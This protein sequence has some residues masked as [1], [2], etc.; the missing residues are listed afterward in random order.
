MKTSLQKAGMRM[1]GE[2]YIATVLD[3]IRTAWDAQQDAL[4]GAADRIAQT[5]AAKHSVF[6][7]GCSHAGMLAE[8]VFYR[9]GGLAVLNPI[10]F[11]GVAL[12]T[13]PVTLTSK[14]ERLPGLGTII[15]EENH[16][17]AGDLLI[18][19]SNSG[20]NTV[21]IEMA[22]QARDRGVYTIAF[23]SMQH[24]R[25]VTSRHP[26][27]KKLFEVCDLVI[28]NCGVPGDA[29]IAVPGLAE[30]MGP[31]STAVASALI[32]GIVIEAVERLLQMGVAPPVFRSANLDGG[33]AHNQ[34]I[35]DEYKD[36]I[37]YM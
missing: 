35:F 33:D 24:T 10:F 15:L 7:F 30:P 23:T 18:V 37:F 20:R 17:Q 27:G 2:T 31:T 19:Q 5:I 21:P 3:T 4:L 14:L 8:E 34:K 6:V 29:A 13:R 22:M 11:S 25:S 9:T 28:D 32:H 36:N 26:S 12:T 16:V 1:Q